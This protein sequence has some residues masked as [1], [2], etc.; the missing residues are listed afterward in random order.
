[1]SKGAVGGKETKV[2]I[3]EG[4]RE[5]AGGF[6]PR[7]GVIT[8]KK[9]S[10]LPV[11]GKRWEW[12]G[13]SVLSQNKCSRGGGRDSPY[14]SF[15]TKIPHSRISEGSAVLT[16]S[17]KGK[18]GSVAFK[19]RAE[20]DDVEKRGFHQE[21]PKGVVVFRRTMLMSADGAFGERRL[22]RLSHR[23]RGSG[24]KFFMGVPSTVG[25]GLQMGGAWGR[26]SLYPKRKTILTPLMSVQWAQ[27]SHWETSRRFRQR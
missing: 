3:N 12:G 14:S 5:K 18:G 7:R 24:R 16:K 6:K 10:R 25:R 8:L 13:K 17:E 9:L 1:M 22:I 21:P 2:T 19:R 15:R 26:A 11:T 4:P 23:V 20:A 27:K